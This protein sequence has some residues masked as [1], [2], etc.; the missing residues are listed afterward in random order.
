ML[1]STSTEIGKESRREVAHA[2]GSGGSRGTRWRE[3]PEEG[4]LNELDFTVH[5]R[6]MGRNW[7]RDRL[8]L[9]IGLIRCLP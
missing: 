9:G 1:R 6:P 4:H 7:Q 5:S 8:Y 3:L 2:E